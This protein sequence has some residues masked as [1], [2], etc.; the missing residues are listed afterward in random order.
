MTCKEVINQVCE[1][2]GE[3]P[4]SPVCLAIQDHLI[5][6]ENCTN[7]YDSL[8]KTVTLYKNYSADLPKGAHERLMNVLKLVEKK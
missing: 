7:F 3:L 6:C 8:E 5:E 4:D 2:L 1:H